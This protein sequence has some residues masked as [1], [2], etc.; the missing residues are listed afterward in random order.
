MGQEKPGSRPEY[1]LA[2]DCRDGQITNP[3]LPF[4]LR[5]L[6]GS[7]YWDNSTLRLTGLR[8]DGGGTAVTVDGEFRLPAP[9]TDLAARVGP[10]P[11][12]IEPYSEA[13]LPPVPGPSVP[14]PSVP[15]PPVPPPPGEWDGHR[16]DALVTHE[17]AIAYGGGAYGGGAYTIVGGEPPRV[18]TGDLAVSVTDLPVSER[19]P[20]RL[21]PPIEKFLQILH[22]SGADRRPPAG[23]TAT[24]PAAGPSPPSL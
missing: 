23:S 2:V 19:Y 3:L 12:G 24:T 16:N 11:R 17:R 8:A 22:P 13:P 18:V 15:G 7:V 21:P 6:Q 9:A 20:G 5:H 4:A 1:Q 14:G 10:V